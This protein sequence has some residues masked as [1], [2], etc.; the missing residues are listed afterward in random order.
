MYHWAVRD[1]IT[2]SIKSRHVYHD[3]AEQ[4]AKGDRCEIVPI[5]AE[6]ADPHRYRDNPARALGRIG[7]SSTSERKAATSRANGKRGGRPKLA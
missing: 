1:R 7:G 5:N 3:D 6:H 2:G 4:K